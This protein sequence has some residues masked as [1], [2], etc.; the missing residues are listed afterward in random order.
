MFEF[1]IF[2]FLIFDV[3]EKIK[4]QYQINSIDLPIHYSLLTT[5]HSLLTTHHSP[6]LTQFQPAHFFY[7]Q[8]CC[9]SGN[10]FADAG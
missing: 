5:D 6:L 7:F 10:T 9:Y 1:W 4:Y 3:G 8:F 2:E